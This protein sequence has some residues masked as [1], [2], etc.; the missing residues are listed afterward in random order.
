MAISFDVA[1]NGADDSSSPLAWNHTIKNS[2]CLLVVTI[3]TGSLTSPAVT[4]AVTAG[5]VSM[6]KVRADQNTAATGSKIETSMWLLQN[7]PTGTISIS[8]SYSGGSTPH[9]NGMACSYLGAQRSSY[10]DANNGTNGTTTGDKTVSVTTVMDNCWVVGG[11]QNL[12]G[13][14]ATLTADQTTRVNSS[15]APPGSETNVIRM[16]DTNG[17]VTPP[18]ATT[19]GFVTGGTLNQSYALSFV[20]IAPALV[21]PSQ[22]TIR[23][24]AFS[25][26]LA[27]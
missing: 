11:G 26:G 17:V 25:P 7:P 2:D 24:A 27:R 18:G 8:A 6:V 3:T 10:G 9:A 4:S 12:A 1:S 22:N 21:K 5:G 13:T 15:Y 14:G 19:V 20:S 16:E 23:P